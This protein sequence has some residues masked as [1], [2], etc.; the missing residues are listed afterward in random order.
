MYVDTQTY[1]CG[2]NAKC[3]WLHGHMHVDT[4]PLAHEYI[5]SKLSGVNGTTKILLSG[6]NNSAKF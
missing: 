4:W 1:A 2:Y 6:I 5:A 3:M